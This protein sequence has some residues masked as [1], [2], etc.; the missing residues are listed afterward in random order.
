MAGREKVAY[1]SLTAPA[2]TTLMD[3]KWLSPSVFELGL[4]RPA[5]FS[6]KSGHA[7]QLIHQAYQ[8]YYS[9]IS[10]PDDAR[11][12]FC[13]RIIDPEGLA[14]ILSTAA[15]GSPVGICG[16][17][18]YFN[19]RPSSRPPVF[20]ATD[21][22]IAPFVSM[23]RSGVT[24]FTMLHGAR[25]A[26]ELFYRDLFESRARKYVPCICDTPNDGIEQCDRYHRKLVDTLKGHVE[27]GCYD[28]YLCGWE[29]TIKSVVD[30]IDNFYPHS[31]VH[32][33]VFY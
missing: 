8:R 4:R 32:V 1:R 5:D 7:I 14:S 30:T 13:I 12:Q 11:L 17:F 19:Y 26:Q 22:G 23:V 2:T 3:R 21:T 9:P 24:G 6:F 28:F 10:T 31:Y 18:G 27:Q 16:P 25:S 15:I 29:K 20:V 33:E